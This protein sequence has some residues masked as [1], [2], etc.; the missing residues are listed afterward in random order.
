MLIVDDDI[1][2]GESLGDVLEA[3]G[4]KIEKVTSGTAALEKIKNNGFDAALVDLKMPE[5]NGVET[6]RRIKQLA[7]R[8]KV[9][10]MTAYS[11]EDL[12]AEARQTG[13]LCL[14][15]PLNI[16]QVLKELGAGQN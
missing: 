5:M 15:K 13:E 11:S 10:M 4:L 8:V 7:P 16:D 14:F 9:I 6:Y 2:M 12:V 3:Q 1:E